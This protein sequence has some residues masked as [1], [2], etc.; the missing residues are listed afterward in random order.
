MATAKA[1]KKPSTA[2][3]KVK[4]TA[5]VSVQDTIAKELAELG[6][7][8]GS[9]AGGN[10]IRVSQSKMFKLPD[11]TEHPG[12][13]HMVIV[14]HITRRSWYD[15]PFD[16]KNPSPP[17]C[18]AAS[19]ET[20]GMLPM[21]AS[22]DKQSNACTGCPN[23]EWGTA[24][25][26]NGKACKESRDLAVIPDDADATTKPFFLE[27]SPT[28]LKAYDGYVRSIASSLQKASF[29]VVTEV[30]FDP[31]LDYPSLRFSN[32]QPA[33]ADLIQ[34]AANL[35][36]GARQELLSPLDF[37]G[38]KPITVTKKGRK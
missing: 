5:I 14:D 25:Q 10:R 26:G 24:N 1:A 18:A 35:K 28:G 36:T 31:N 27:V 23:D 38:Y 4:P 32:P 17:A 34:I 30:S 6:A 2:V 9:S 8:T 33:S 29:Q 22:P 20:T 12:P 13:L 21:A 7:A 3:A 37:S 11:G 16:K 15:R 19:R